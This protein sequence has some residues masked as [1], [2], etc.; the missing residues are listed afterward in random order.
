MALFS[1]RPLSPIGIDIGTRC[2]KAAQ[3]E[4]SEERNRV[5]AL[6]QHLLPVD[7]ASPAERT[8]AVRSGIAAVLRMG[9]FKGRDV[10]LSLNAQQLF[11]QNVRVPRLPDDEL[12]KVVRWEA[13]ERL[14]EDFGESEIRHLVAGDIRTPTNTGEGTEAR[15]EVVVLACRRKEIQEMIQMLETLSLRPVAIDVSA[16]A[17]VRTSHAMMRR[18][19]DEQAAFLFIDIGAGMT[20]VVVTRGHEILLI[21]SLAVGGLSMDRLVARKLKLNLEDAALARQQSGN[22]TGEAIDPDLAR[23][24]ADS[25]RGELESLAGELLMC[26]RYHSVTFRGN[27]I[28]K[29]VLFGGESCPQLADQL[30]GCIDIPCESGDPFQGLDA[31]PL[32]EEQLKASRRGQWVVALGLCTKPARSV[33]A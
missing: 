10:V 15:R 11:V 33:A 27:R 22:A 9:Q 28:T 23:V 4:L 18:R 21:K 30:S 25:V 17:L 24:V 8:E 26:I 13:E 6:A 12:T 32:V 7:S 3:L 14:P 29:A 2:I 5:V 20:T 19:A 31:S 16:C 1:R